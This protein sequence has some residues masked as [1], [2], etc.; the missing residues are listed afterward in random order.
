MDDDMEAYR[1]LCE[2]RHWL[3][4]GYTSWGK[5]RELRGRIAEKRGEEA[6][7][8]LVQDMREQWKCRRQW[9]EPAA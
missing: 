7:E 1:R 5:V 4:Q 3:R 6:A 8:L 9:M 2:A